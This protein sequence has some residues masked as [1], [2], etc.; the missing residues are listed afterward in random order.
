[1]TAGF[2]EGERAVQRRAGTEAHADRL[3]GMLDRPWLDGG[4]SRFLSGRQF[5]ALAARDAGGR[6]W[7][8]PLTGRPGM[9][10]AHGT[11]LKV[12]ATPQAGDPLAGLPTGQPVGLIAI[13]FAIR[14]R[15]RINGTLEKATDKDLTIAVEQAYGNCPQYIQMRDLRPRPAFG[16]GAAPRPASDTGT[17]RDALNEDDRALIESTDTFFLGTVHPTRGADCSHRGGPPGVLRVDG[18][19]LWWPDYPGNKMFNSLGNLEVDPTAALLIPHFATGRVL[20]LSGTAVTEW[21]TS[22]PGDDGGTGR[23]IRFTPEAIQ[24]G[25]PLAINAGQVTH[26]QQNPSLT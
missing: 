11:V 14:R 1:M 13:E 10:D 4:W 24:T 6:L 12:H 16:L 7:V 18:K 2:H 15:V 5:A 8:S 19:D 3:E 20:H 21:D 25:P 23:R 9:L 17:P 26:Y 22:G